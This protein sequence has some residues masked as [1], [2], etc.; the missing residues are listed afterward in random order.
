MDQSM[1][2]RVLA[3]PQFQK[4]A[5]AKA[6]LGWSFSAL[7]LLVYVVYILFIGWVP[8]YFAVPLLADG[9]T[10]WGIVFGLFVIVFAFAI[11]GIYVHQANGRFE[12]MTQEVVKEITQEESR[13]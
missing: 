6:V 11:T 5:R 4:M 8:E 3:H 12:A 13:R 1:A 9:A 10:T 7:M 2:A